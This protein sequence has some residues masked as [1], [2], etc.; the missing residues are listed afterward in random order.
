HLIPDVVAAL[1]TREAVS[2]IA[3]RGRTQDPRSRFRRAEVPSVLRTSPEPRRIGFL[4]IAIRTG[5]GADTR[6]RR[7][8]DYDRRGDRRRQQAHHREGNPFPPQPRLV[9]L[10][11]HLLHRLQ[12]E[13]RRIQAHGTRTVRDSALRQTYSRL[14]DRFESGWLVPPQSRLFQ[15]LH[16]TDDD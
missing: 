12:G 7:R 8:M 11:I 13:F 14:S 6:R 2:E 5:G 16:R 15:L 3:A 1:A 10:G 4:S 9:L